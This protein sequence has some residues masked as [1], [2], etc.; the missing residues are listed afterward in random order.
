MTVWYT[1]WNWMRDMMY[2]F[3]E[4]LFTVGM[5]SLIFIIQGV[6]KKAEQT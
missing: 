5:V 6:S 1:W 3:G 2:F 4:L